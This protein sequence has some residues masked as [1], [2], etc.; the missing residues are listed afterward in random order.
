MRFPRPGRP[1]FLLPSPS[2]PPRSTSG[3]LTDD[4]TSVGEHYNS[5][6]TH[7]GP[8]NPITKRH[9]GDLGNIQSVLRCWIL[10][11]RLFR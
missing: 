7:G 9:V 3:N 1:A 10:L 4:C 6:N 5:F 2:Q 11:M 8:T